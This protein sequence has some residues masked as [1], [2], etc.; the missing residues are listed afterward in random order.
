MADDLHAA[1]LEVVQ[2][3]RGP[4]DGEFC[5][6]PIGYPNVWRDTPV[7]YA[8]YGRR[9]RS[10]KVMSF[11]NEIKS[12]AELAA[13]FGKGYDPNNPDTV[14]WLHVDAEVPQPRKVAYGD[15]EKYKRPQG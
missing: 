4:A 10:R 1:E 8:L 2:L 9:Q 15:P 11:K 13:H 6:V 14:P 5:E 7:G 12:P 3:V